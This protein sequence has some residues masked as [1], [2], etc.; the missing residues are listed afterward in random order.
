MK[1]STRRRSR[2]D[3]QQAGNVDASDLHLCV[4]LAMARVLAVVLAAAHLLDFELRTFDQWLNDLCRDAGPGNRRGPDDA[5]SAAVREQNLVKSDRIAGFRGVHEV[6][7]Q[8]VTAGD[9][10]L[11]TAVFDVREHGSK[12]PQNSG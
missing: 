4:T 3:D 1:L 11:V 2:L 7:Q 6:D 12:I 10:V 8:R 5:G 9:S